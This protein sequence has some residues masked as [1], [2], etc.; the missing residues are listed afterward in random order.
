[1][2]QSMNTPAIN[3]EQ[4]KKVAPLA[5]EGRVDSDQF[6]E[7]AMKL[8]Q[9]LDNHGIRYC[10]WKSN[11]RLGKSLRGET[12]LDLLVDRNHQRE[13]TDQ[14]LSLGFIPLRSDPDHHYP[15][16]VD[17]LGFDPKTAKFI[18]LHIHYRLIMGMKYIKNHHLPVEQALLDNTTVKHGVQIP[19][20]E[21]ELILLVIRAHLKYRMSDALK[22]IL[23]R[24]PKAG[25]SQDILDEIEYLS[26]Q[27]TTADVQNALREFFPWLN[28]ALVETALNTLNDKAISSWSVFRSSRKSKRALS[29]YQRYGGLK[30]AINYY[31]IRLRRHRRIRGLIRR[32]WGQRKKKTPAS[33]GLTLALIGNDGSGK[34]TVL[35]ELN[36][37]LSWQ[38]KVSHHYL[39]RNQHGTATWMIDMLYNLSR[40]T[41]TV[42]KRLLGRR[43]TLSQLPGKLTRLLKAFRILSEDRDRLKRYRLGRREAGQGFIV[44]FERYPLDRYSSLAHTMDGPKIQQALDGQLPRLEKKLRAWERETYRKIQ[45]PDHIFILKVDPETARARKPDHGLE[46]IKEKDRALNSLSHEDLSVTEI[47]GNAPLQSVLHT[48]KTQVWELL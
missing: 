17:Y 2:G 1:M 15:A 7:I 46:M 4:G 32:I 45:P 13:F 24:D 43:N 33:G 26:Q 23:K 21:L 20:P 27:V 22:S 18:H 30:A 44:L 48:I 16:I 35:S 38:L 14:L 8:F 42:L 37:W 10:H 9:S 34:S 12:D 6:L 39:G 28:P 11:L 31:R 29:L 5:Q 47:N 3:Q 40:S 41:E 36:Q 19:H 25:L